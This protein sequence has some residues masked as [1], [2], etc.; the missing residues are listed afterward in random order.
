[1]LGQMP[2]DFKASFLLKLT[3]E[4]IENTE[5][6]KSLTIKEKAK[7]FVEEEKEGK[8][9]LLIN[10]SEEVVEEIKKEEIRDL[11]NVKIK[12]EHETISRMEKLD[13]LS[14]LKAISK[15]IQRPRGNQIQRGNQIPRIPSAL[16]IPET[17][18]PETVRHIR[19]VA[20]P[21]EIDLGKLNIIAKDP[22]VK[23]IECNGPEENILV[24]GIMGR[25]PTSVKLSRD[26]IEQLVGRFA[27]AAKIPVNEGLFKAA[28]GNLVISAVISEIVGV[29]FI[30]RKISVGI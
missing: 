12:R 16:R 29:K 25:K 27:A 3:R 10:Q 21:E 24:V 8:A 15:T 19:P 20:T 11:V 22:L 13:L 17:Q 23:I 14:E 6:Y 4:L 28:F 18:L 7:E 1:M 30:I 9:P 2:E 5:A 26:E